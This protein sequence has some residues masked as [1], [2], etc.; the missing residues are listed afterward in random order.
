[1]SA[2]QNKQQSAGTL[3]SFSKLKLKG[4]ELT[5]VHE[6]SLKTHCCLAFL[7]NS[8]KNSQHEAFQVSKLKLKLKGLELTFVHEYSLQTHCCLACLQTEQATASMNPCT[9]SKCFQGQRQGLDVGDSTS[10]DGPL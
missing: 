9:S 5:F 7:Q 4:L 2:K 8:T 6:Y 1:M 10:K 3:P